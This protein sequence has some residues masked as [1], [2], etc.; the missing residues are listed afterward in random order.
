MEILEK[1]KEGFNSILVEVVESLGNSV[2]TPFLKNLI[3]FGGKLDLELAEKSLSFEQVVIYHRIRSN[4][5]SLELTEEIEPDD[6]F[7]TFGYKRIGKP[8]MNINYLPKEGDN[9]AGYVKISENDV[10]TINSELNDYLNKEKHLEEEIYKFF[11]KEG[12]KSFMNMVDFVYHTLYHMAPGFNYI[13]DNVF[14]NFYEFNNTIKALKGKTDRYILDDLKGA[15]IKE[16]NPIEVK[17]VYNTYWLLKSGGPPRAEEFNGFQLYCTNLHEFLD[18]KIDEYTSYSSQ[19]VKFKAKSIADKALYLADLKKQLTND[20]QFV[21]EINGLTVHKKE[22]LIDKK[23]IVE[24]DIDN[25]PVNLL[26]YLERK[27]TIKTATNLEDLFYRVIAKSFLESIQADNNSM[28]N[29]FEE[30]LTLII[31]L[32]IRDTQADIGMS[33]S[34]RDYSQFINA[35]NN[36]DVETICNWK[37]TNYFCCVVPSKSLKSFLIGKEGVLSNILIAISARMQYNSW[38]YMPG[39]FPFETV[40]NNRHFY[41]PPAMAD[42]AIWSNQHHKGHLNAQVKYSIRS[43]QPLIYKGK[44]Y[45]AFFDLRLMKQKGKPFSTEDLKKAIYYTSIL[46]NLYQALL[47]TCSKNNISFGIQAFTKQWYKKHYNN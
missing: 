44:S 35:I 40:P 13:D 17:F 2:N 34:L 29:F 27:Y 24:P 19:E 43:P 11:G 14:S 37:Q 25:L 8:I 5:L 46:R 1:R 7:I 47:D 31:E 28:Y 9:V 36:D 12:D 22:K 38:H 15:N 3:T 30:L 21:R 41:F 39:H 10:Y 32:A 4:K 42:T 33:R 23:D 18:K 45:N 6:T 26:N 16:C 20:Y